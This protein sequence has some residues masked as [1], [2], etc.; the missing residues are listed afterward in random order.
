MREPKPLPIVIYDDREWV[1][2]QLSRHT[3]VRRYGSLIVRGQS[4][5]EHFLASLPDWARERTVIIEPGAKLQNFFSTLPMLDRKTG[6]ILIA[7]RGAVIEPQV[8][9]QIIMRMPYADQAVV[10]RQRNP[11][12][13]YFPNPEPLQDRWSNFC[14]APLHLLADLDDAADQIAGDSPLVDIGE[15]PELLKFIS[16]S[17]SARV[18]NQVSFDNLI[19]RKRSSDRAKMKAEHD[20]YNL[21]P[22]SMRPWMV[23]AFDYKEDEHGAEYAM[24]RYHFSDA[25]FQWVHNAWT[26]ATFSDF[27]ARAFYFLDGRAKRTSTRAEVEAAAK[28]LFVDKVEERRR[29]L[30]GDAAGAALLASIRSGPGGQ[31]LLELFDRYNALIK[32]HW[33]RF[34]DGNMVVGHGDPCLSNILYDPM[35]A[36]LKLIDPRGAVSEEQLWTHSL[37]DYCKLTHSV[38]GDYDYINN[39]QFSICLDERAE[40]CLKINGRPPAPYKEEFSRRLDAVVDPIA[41]RLGQASLFLSML[42]LHLDHPRKVVAFLL[43]AKSILDELE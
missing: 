24:L 40:L 37:Y 25:A 21:I 12:F 8:L 29:R 36:T 28:S 7:A 5:R 23:G 11:L 18:F 34:S 39:Q 10:D 31:R 17:T 2:D 26:P 3:G 42:P 4:V 41:V 13:R 6:V 1:A 30:A 16:G 15:L 43:R 27:L 9:K 14:E 22:V 35:T 20:Y 33:R 19:Y 38:L 32:K